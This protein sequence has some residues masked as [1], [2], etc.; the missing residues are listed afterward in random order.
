MFLRKELLTK[1]S[2]EES[3]RWMPIIKLFNGK[4]FAGG[5]IEDR[6]SVLVL[7]VFSHFSRSKRVIPKGDI[8]SIDF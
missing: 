4:D 6:D 2:E 1:Y 8:L 7:E 5:M 3:S